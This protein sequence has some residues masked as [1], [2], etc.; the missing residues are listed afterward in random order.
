MRLKKNIFVFPF[1]VIPPGSHI[2][3]WGAGNIG[4]QYFKQI[5]ASGYCLID[6]VVDTY[7]EKEG[8]FPVPVMLPE[9]FSEA[10]NF[11]FVVVAVADGKAGKHIVTMLESFGIPLAK[12]VPYIPRRTYHESIV[13]PDDAVRFKRG[14]FLQKVRILLRIY[15]AVGHNL[16]RV[17]NEYDGG[18]IMLDDFHNAGIA[19]SFGISDDVSWDASMADAGLD[20]YM[21]D[22][23]IGELPEQRSSFH[24]FQKGIADSRITEKL[25]TLE[26]FIA[27]NGHNDK[28]HM[29]LKMDVE[30]AEW[31]FLEML[32]ES[33]L[34]QFDQIVME[35]HG[36]IDGKMDDKILAGIIKINK[37]HGVVHVHANNCGTE[38]EWKGICYTDA[39]E[40]TWA[41]RTVYDLSPVDRIE[42]P[43]AID[44]PCDK[45]LPETILGRWNEE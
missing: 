23:T 32:N 11:D 36:L 25:D 15:Q 3:L 31:G 5:M 14:E 38:L 2:I 10:K 28:Y 43:L 4:R 12:I 7:P 24:F 9:F 22:H 6:A 27:S 16:I 19:Y 34:E 33:L 1:E 21:Y 30:G 42:L 45:L 18:Y 17:G 40:V 35:I 13:V 26:H 20:V 41:S 37:T 44:A 8:N 39:L 29:I